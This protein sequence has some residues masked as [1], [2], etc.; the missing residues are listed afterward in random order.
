MTIVII[1]GGLAGSAAA[2]TLARAGR[3]VT[4]IEREPLPHHKVCGEF[5]S[6]EALLYLAAL[7]IDIP[8]LGAVPIH[9][10]RLASANREATLPFA[11]MSL[12]RRTLDEHLLQTAEQAG[13]NVL[14]GYP[15]ES[16]TP[17][18]NTW[19]ITLPSKTLRAGTVFL[20]TGKHDLRAH[21]RPSGR[22]P[23]LVAFKMYFR[24]TPQQAAALGNTVELILYPGGYAGLQPVED[25]AA[26]L[27][28]LIDRRELQR[29]GNWGALLAAM[30]AA[31]PLLRE[32]LHSAQPLLAKPLA[33]SPIPYGYVRNA[34]EPAD[35]LWHLG[36][37]AAV[38]PS[39]TGDGMSIALHSGR[40]AATMYLQGKPPAQFQR[41]LHRE[42]S[43]QVSLATAISRALV[44]PPTR[45]II[46]TAVGIFPGLLDVVAR[47]T[48]IKESALIP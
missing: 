3:D 20:A 5:L 25:D 26:N 30:Q 39:F 17:E 27:T 7:G 42:V 48:R 21:P 2:I 19:R 22:Q 18:T 1:G 47:R 31:S 15:V 33:I 28:C 34:P 14:R 9:T 40:L 45:S 44:W 24:L 41:Q 11:A 23:S 12:T 37:Q 29:L 35:N 4:L 8:A 10:V 36:D 16:L 13:V 6:R 46:T 32:R 43:Q 38:I